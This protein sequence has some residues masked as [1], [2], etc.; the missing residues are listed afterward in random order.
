MTR[1]SR[2]RTAL[3]LL[4][5]GAP[6]AAQTPAAA[7]PPARTDHVV[8]PGMTREQVVASLGKPLGA[9]TVGARTFLFY[10]NGR[11]RRVGMQDVVFLE[12]DGVV[13][14]IF[15]APHRRYTG[16]SSLQP[17]VKPAP[18]HIIAPARGL[19]PARATALDSV[20]RR[21]SPQQRDTAR[22]RM[23]PAPAPTRR[24]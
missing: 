11:E 23:N 18:T 12:N 3:A 2:F 1:N 8:E 15:R 9:R 13:D 6:L 16:T 14:A 21:T 20:S 5:L 10:S 17:G 4:A 7:A 22:V 19:S 24:P